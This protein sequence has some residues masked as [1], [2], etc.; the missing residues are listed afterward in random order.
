MRNYSRA[1]SSFHSQCLWS[2]YIPQCI[3]ETIDLTATRCPHGKMSHLYWKLQQKNKISYHL[4]SDRKMEASAEWGCSKASDSA[5]FVERAPSALETRRR[6]LNLWRCSDQ[7]CSHGAAVRALLVGSNSCQ[8]EKDFHILSAPPGCVKW[9]QPLWFPSLADTSRGWKH[10]FIIAFN[11]TLGVPTVPLS[12]LGLIRRSFSTF[13]IWAF[14]LVKRPQH[15]SD[16]KSTRKDVI[17][18][19][20][21]LLFSI[22]PPLK[23]IVFLIEW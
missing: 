18:K 2:S 8:Y 21:S 12:R 5:V 1:G 7:S 9:A 10:F 16:A 3:R 13:V 22:L 14:L 17:S 11:S 15:R 6:P 20:V 19:V 4:S 23:W